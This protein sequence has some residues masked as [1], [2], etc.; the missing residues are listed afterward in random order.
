MRCFSGL[1]HFQ[2]NTTFGKR[3]R[4]LTQYHKKSGINMETY[5]D[6]EQWS[7]MTLGTGCTTTSWLI[8]T[9]RYGRLNNTRRCVDLV[10]SMLGGQM[11]VASIISPTTLRSKTQTSLGVINGQ[12]LAADGRQGKITCSWIVMRPMR[13]A[14][15]TIITKMPDYQNRNYGT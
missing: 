12:L 1:S 13:C 11:R 6:Y 14:L 7:G 8:D 9:S 15:V 2:K 3:P 5:K 4:H 10:L